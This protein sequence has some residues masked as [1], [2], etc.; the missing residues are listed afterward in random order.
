MSGDLIVAALAELGRA[1]VIQPDEA[2]G[3]L[4]VGYPT[5]TARVQRSRMRATWTIGPLTL[6]EEHAAALK[7]IMLPGEK[8]LPALRRLIL[9]AARKQ[10]AP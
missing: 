2:A 6:D 8:A 3:M 7:S 4:T 5:S 10:P 9:E 1:K